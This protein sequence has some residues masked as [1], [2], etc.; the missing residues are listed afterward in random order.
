MSIP[1]QAGAESKALK[2]ASDKLAYNVRQV[3]ELSGL[4]RATV[5]AA[6]RNGR[7][8]ARKQGARTLVL[9]DDLHS[10]LEGLPVLGT[11]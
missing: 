2:S 11:V 4:C 7:L 6:I 8:K 9:R 1:R 5:Y 3:C 10:W